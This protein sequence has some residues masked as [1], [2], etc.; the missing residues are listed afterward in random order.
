[1]LLQAAAF[2]L[3]LILRLI[4]KAGTPKGL[5]DLK[6]RMVLALLRVLSRTLGSPGAYFRVPKNVPIRSS[7]SEQSA[8]ESA[9]IMPLWRIGVLTR[10]C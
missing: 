10:D 1:M 6:R 7:L 2:N 3:A 8:A 4:T 9:Q 5:A